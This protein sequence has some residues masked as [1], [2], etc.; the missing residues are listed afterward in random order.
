MKTIRKAS[1]W[2]AGFW[3]L[4]VLV[5]LVSGIIGVVNDRHAPGAFDFVYAVIAI[6]VAGSIFWYVPDWFIT[7][8]QRSIL[9][10]LIDPNKEVHIKGAKTGTSEFHHVEI[11]HK[12]P[13]AGAEPFFK[14]D[15]YGRIIFDS[16]QRP[17]RFMFGGIFLVVGLLIGLVIFL[18]S[19]DVGFFEYFWVAG[20]CAFAL[21]SMGLVYE[22]ELTRHTNVVDRKAGWFFIV[23]KQRY[24]LTD[25]HRVMVESTFQRSRYDRIRDR[26]RSVAPR[27]KVDLAG[28]RRLNL[29]VFNNIADARRMAAELSAYLGL[30]VAEK[31]EVHV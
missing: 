12:D 7:R 6:A 22:V 24:M 9:D 17:L 30:P 31:T 29:R 23:R 2:F 14:E 20:W 28:N 21:G 18:V 1:R 5:L 8:Y 16:T 27:F 19:D 13:T 26:Y 15:A 3:F 25:F 4:V 11:V 10:A